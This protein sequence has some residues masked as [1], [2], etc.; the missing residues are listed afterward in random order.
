MTPENPTAKQLEI[1]QRI[2]DGW[3]LR[4]QRWEGRYILRHPNTQ[5]I[6]DLSPWWRA[7]LQ[8]AVNGWVKAP[9]HGLIHPPAEI[10]YE[11][12]DAGCALVINATTAHM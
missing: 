7:V 1:I 12:T 3:R 4:Y 2:Q 11:L 5:D 9:S 10:R 6:V 8:I